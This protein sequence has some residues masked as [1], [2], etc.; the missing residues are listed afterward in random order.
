MGTMWY[1]GWIDRV[2]MDSN[3]LKLSAHL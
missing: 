1:F 3:Y 2:F